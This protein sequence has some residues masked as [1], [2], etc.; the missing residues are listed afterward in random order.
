MWFLLESSGN[1][2]TM[3]DGVLM[4]KYFYMIT[5]SGYRIKAN[6]LKTKIYSQT[7]FCLLL[8][9]KDLKK[10]RKGNSY[11]GQAQGSLM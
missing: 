1:I 7:K 8:I 6:N 2:V 4:V 10:K 9:R 5:I 11:I 3:L